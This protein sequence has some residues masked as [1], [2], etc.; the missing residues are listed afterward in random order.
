[1]TTETL[2]IKDIQKLK[3]LKTIL[4]YDQPLVEY[5]NLQNEIYLGMLID[6]DGTIA[7]WY[8]IKVN[9]LTIERLEKNQMDLLSA[10][11]EPA[12]S[13]VY[14]VKF[15]NNIPIEIEILNSSTLPVNTLP[16]KGLFIGE[17]VVMSAPIE[18]HHDGNR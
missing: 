4:Y 6:N 5:Y 9:E 10:F 1:M 12:D 7:S 3:L 8:Y 15:E 13:K 17:E 11:R 18:K 14:K 16:D 2:N